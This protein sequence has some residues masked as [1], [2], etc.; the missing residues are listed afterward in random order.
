MLIL[1]LRGQAPVLLE[2]LR[3]VRARSRRPGSREGEVFGRKLREKIGFSLF[4]WGDFFL[5]GV[6]SLLQFVFVGGGG[7]CISGVGVGFCHGHTLAK[8]NRRIPD[9]SQC[10]CFFTWFGVDH[11]SS[12]F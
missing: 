3:Q 11:F 1:A 2:H 8:E 6:G 4:F 12:R 5:G 9:R 10:G 7:V